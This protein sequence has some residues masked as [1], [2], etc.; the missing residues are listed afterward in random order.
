MIAKGS[1][2]LWN[3]IKD[4]ERMLTELQKHGKVTNFEAET[5]AYTDRHIYVLFSAKQL[6]E[7]IFGMVMDI[8]DRKQAEQKSHLIGLCR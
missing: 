6:G 2:E 3:D 4:R 1:L 7:N 5:I 8:T